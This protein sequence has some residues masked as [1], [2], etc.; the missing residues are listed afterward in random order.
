MLTLLMMF[1]SLECQPS[2][3]VRVAALQ[4]DLQT[5]RSQ[6]ELYKVQHN[7]RV[8]GSDGAV[9]P[10][11]TEARF[12]DQLMRRTDAEGTVRD[13]GEFGPYVQRFPK[14]SFAA[15]GV[16]DKV[17]FGTDQRKANSKTEGWY[18][19]TTTGSLYAAGFIKY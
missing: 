11:F 8:P 9:K 5:L 15:S 1:I 4:S 6:V 10:A 2:G 7:D 17:A 12:K 18:F 13:N 16:Q 14:N 19:N 3:N